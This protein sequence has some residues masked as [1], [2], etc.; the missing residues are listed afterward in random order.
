MLV[1][2][3]VNE[4]RTPDSHYT[5]LVKTEIPDKLYKA[6]C[7]SIVLDFI[8][9]ITL[10][11]FSL[12]LLLTAKPWDV[13]NE[14]IYSHRWCWQAT[15]SQSVK[16]DSHPRNTSTHFCSTDC[17]WKQLSP[18]TT[19]TQSVNQFTLVRWKLVSSRHTARHCKADL[20]IQSMW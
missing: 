16:P 10:L 4:D 20:A 6:Y 7:L 5:P 15:T 11:L 18:C 12:L 8:T 9:I 1:G 14:S 2:N 17:R 13:I 19:A 3:G